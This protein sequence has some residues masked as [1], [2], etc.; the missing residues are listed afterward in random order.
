[1]AEYTTI[2]GDTWDQIA[3]K[4]YVSD[5]ATRDIMAENGTR[6][7][8]LLTVWRFAYGEQLTVPERTPD[9]STVAQLPPWR[10]PDA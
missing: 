4:V 7:P 10:R 2:Q 5:V 6:D 8:E 9:T 1:M 3:L